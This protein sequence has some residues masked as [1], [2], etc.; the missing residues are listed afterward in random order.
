MGILGLSRLGGPSCCCD[1]ALQS[2]P[3]WPRGIVCF[4][5]LNFR[6]VPGQKESKRE[7]S[8]Y[9]VDA[10]SATVSVQAYTLLVLTHRRPQLDDNIQYD[11]ASVF[12]VSTKV[13]KEC[14]YPLNPLLDLA[15]S[16]I[17]PIRGALSPNDLLM[18][19]L[20]SNIFASQVSVHSLPRPYASPS[21][22]PPLAVGLASA[23]LS[24]RETADFVH[25]LSLPSLSLGDFVD[26]VYHT[27]SI[28]E[29]QKKSGVV[30]RLAIGV[31]LEVYR[32][33]Y[34]LFAWRPCSYAPGRNRARTAKGAEKDSLNSRWKSAHDLCSLVICNSAFDDCRD[35]DGPDLS[36]CHVRSFALRSN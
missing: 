4:F 22:V 23:I 1:G 20:S 6:I 21:D 27:L 7:R 33:A 28:L 12:N 34:L 29:K 3:C 2:V 18:C 25:V 14:T 13:G 15:Q 11:T 30:I 16:W 32:C 36:E 5:T 26:I 31:C 17:V 19:T 35:A 9:W 10:V 8:S 24:R